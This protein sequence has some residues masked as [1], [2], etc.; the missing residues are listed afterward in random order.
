MRRP[1]NIWKI[2]RGVNEL[3]DADLQCG[4]EGQLLHVLQQ[5]VPSLGEVAEAVEQRPLGHKGPGHGGDCQ[6]LRL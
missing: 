5:Q 1:G 2:E 4:A 3:G 6:H